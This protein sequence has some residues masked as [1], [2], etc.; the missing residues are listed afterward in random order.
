MITPVEDRRTLDSEGRMMPWYTRPC[1]EWL[2]TIDFNNKKV[3]EFGCGDSTKWYKSRG[4]ITY[5]VDDISKWLPKMHGYTLA[6]NTAD[7][8][9]AVDWKTEYDFIIIDGLYRDDCTGAA[10]AHLAKGGYL[11]A[12]NFEQA[13]AELPDWPITRELTK[14]MKGTFYKE[15]DHIDWV[16]AVWQKP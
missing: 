11:I 5:G 12:D 2:E 7:Y 4:A 16:T 15:P 3:F 8:I 1:L 10:L 13:S 14:N 6:D 9:R